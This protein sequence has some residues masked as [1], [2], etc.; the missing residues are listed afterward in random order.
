M[1]DRHSR[2][3][4]CVIVQSLKRGLGAS[5]FTVRSGGIYGMSAPQQ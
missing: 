4:R 3:T 5:A 2:K 1:H